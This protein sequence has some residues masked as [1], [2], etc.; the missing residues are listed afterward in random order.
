MFQLTC[1]Q[2]TYKASTSS[3]TC[4]SLVFRKHAG[5]VEG[6]PAGTQVRRSAQPQAGSIL[7]VLPRS[8]GPRAWL[9]TPAAPLRPRDSVS[10]LISFCGVLSLGSCP[11]PGLCPKGHVYLPIRSHGELLLTTPGASGSPH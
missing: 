2:L 5:L 8:A 4:T 10:A 1:N 3:Q 7:P 9:P 11:F 6:V